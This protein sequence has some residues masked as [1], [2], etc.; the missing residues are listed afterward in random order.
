M[1][2]YGLLWRRISGGLAGAMLLLPAITL[3]PQLLGPSRLGAQPP[4]APYRWVQPPKGV[5]GNGTPGA[6][7]GTI[8]LAQIASRGGPGP[9]GSAETPPAASAATPDTQAIL[10]FDRSSV[11]AQ[12]GQTSIKV[13]LTP[14]DPEKVGKAPRGLS[15]WSNAY[16]ITADYQPSGQSATNLTVVIFLAVPTVP[17]QGVGP[18]PAGTRIVRWNG[19]SWDPLPTTPAFAQVF[20]TSTTLGTFAVVALGPYPSPRSAFRLVL[21]LVLA[22]LALGVV[23]LLIWARISRAHQEPPRSDM[24]PWAQGPSRTRALRAS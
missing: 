14:Q 16:R 9:V 18:P 6:G 13:S 10:Y 12:P 5:A 4:P 3:S 22:V 1:A 20:A 15:F 24:P 17:D 11:S 8:S 2:S 21:F 19:S 7:T 23:G